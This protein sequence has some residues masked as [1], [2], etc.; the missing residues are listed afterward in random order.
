MCRVLEVVLALLL[1]VAT[2]ACGSKVN[3]KEAQVVAEIEELGGE[4]NIVQFVEGKSVLEADLHKTKVTDAWLE[5]LGKLAKLQ[6]LRLDDT[7]VTDTG[8][9]SS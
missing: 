7:Q 9:E 8:T 3:P 2:S 5:H 4:V 6:S 1:A